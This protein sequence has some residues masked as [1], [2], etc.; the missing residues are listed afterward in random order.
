MLGDNVNLGVNV[1]I[2]RYV[3]FGNNITIGVL[4]MVNRDFDSDC[5]LM[6]VLARNIGNMR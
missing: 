5:M 2:L 1:V 6:G 3:V 4:A